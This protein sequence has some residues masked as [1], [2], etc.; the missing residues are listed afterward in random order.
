MGQ[1]AST[2]TRF[3]LG[4]KEG[5][6]FMGGDALIRYLNHNRFAP[7]LDFCTA[8]LVRADRDSHVATRKH[9]EYGHTHKIPA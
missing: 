2:M 8:A 3:E 7:P 4:A 5:V 1:T 9:E 6:I